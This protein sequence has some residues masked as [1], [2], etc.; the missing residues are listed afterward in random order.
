M[1]YIE[2]W[3]RVSAVTKEKLALSMVSSTTPRLHDDYALKLTSDGRA[4][5]RKVIKRLQTSE[6]FSFTLAEFFAQMCALVYESNKVLEE[7]LRRW[8]RDFEFTRFG[9]DGCCIMAIWSV[10]H[11]FVVL[12]FKGTGLLDLSE[13]LTD[14]SLRK[15]SPKNGVL[16]GLVHSGFFSGFGFPNVDM[17][18]RKRKTPTTFDLDKMLEATW[19]NSCGSMKDDDFWGT[20]LLPHLWQIVKKFDGTPKPHLWITG[21]SLGA[22]TAS[23]FTAMILWRRSKVGANSP[24]EN[25]EWDETFILRGTYTYGTPRTGDTD[26]RAAIQTV[27]RDRYGRFKM[28]DQPQ[29]QFHRIINANDIV[30][31]LPGGPGIS[32]LGTFFRKTKATTHFNRHSGRYE[33]GNGKPASLTLI[34]FQHIGT[35]HLIEYRTGGRHVR[36]R[37]LGFVLFNAMQEFVRGI[38]EAFKQ[39][40]IAGK[41]F[42]LAATF[43]PGV[44][45]FRDHMLSEYV[46]NL[47]ECRKRNAQCKPPPQI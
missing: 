28:R 20:S 36:E 15:T 8:G 18:R 34:D 32:E 12:I 43:V 26:Y 30:A 19:L 16:P 42:A 13:W 35:P 1:G 4:H 14:F 2:L 9:R 3:R 10:E 33:R 39:P 46:L 27:L 44:M 21:H 24:V 29:Y 38:P 25:I 23:I 45:F 7:I 40:T 31:T 5:M 6:K 47:E 22:A 41:A 11:K 37:H 17:V